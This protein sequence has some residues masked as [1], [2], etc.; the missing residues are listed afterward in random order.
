MNHLDYPW[1][2]I[3]SP[4]VATGGRTIPV[5]RCAPTAK[6]VV[7]TTGCDGQLL[8]SWLAEHDLVA[9][10]ERVGMVGYGANAN[11]E[12]LARKVT[13][14]VV[15]DVVQLVDV[16][17]GFVPS[18]SRLGHIGLAPFHSPGHSTAA[19]VT[20]LTRDHL[21]EMLITEPSY[22]II[23]AHVACPRT[24]LAPLDGVQMWA[25]HDLV[26][27]VPVTQRSQAELFALLADHGVKPRWFPEYDDRVACFGDMVAPGMMP[28]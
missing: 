6:P 2:P 4:C 20:R 7:A 10:E 9:M 1:T 3:T 17:L 25:T 15:V 11:A 19:V 28:R 26:D 21:V 5:Y 18:I 14:P 12:V 16:E 24:P 23:D 13:G 8:D 27:G 22:G